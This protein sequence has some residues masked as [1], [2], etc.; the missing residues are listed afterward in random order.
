MNVLLLPVAVLCV[1]VILFGN[2]NNQML[3]T[4]TFLYQCQNYVLHFY[5]K[6]RFCMSYWFSR[7]ALN[8]NK[9]YLEW[10]LWFILSHIPCWR[11][12]FFCKIDIGLQT[13]EKTKQFIVESQSPL[14]V[15]FIFVMKNNIFFFVVDWRF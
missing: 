4:C 10:K 12:S 11:H 6:I 7:A 13:H 15:E 9:H 2:P 5:S 14:Q 3:F 8:W 1:I